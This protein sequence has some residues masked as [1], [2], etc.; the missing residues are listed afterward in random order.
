MYVI[1]NDD[2]SYTK[3]NL[4]KLDSDGLA[5]Q[6]TDDDYINAG[7]I[8]VP[9]DTV[10]EQPIDPVKLLLSKLATDATSLE[11]I[12]TLAQEILTA[13]EGQV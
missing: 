2:G 12:R 7:Y 3:V 8:C 13:T 4:I 5:L 6:P 1:N 10:L 11:K 9:D